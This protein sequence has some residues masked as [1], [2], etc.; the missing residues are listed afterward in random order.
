MKCELITEYVHICVSYVCGRLRESVMSQAVPAV[1]LRMRATPSVVINKTLRKN[2]APAVLRQSKLR[3]VAAIYVTLFLRSVGY[4][5]AQELQNFSETGLLSL[6]SISC[7]CVAAQAALKSW[8]IFAAAPYVRLLFESVSLM[9]SVC[10][11]VLSYLIGSVL[12]YIFIMVIVVAVIFGTVCPLFV[13]DFRFSDR[14]NVSPVKMWTYGGTLIAAFFCA[15]TVVGYFIT[16][17]TGTIGWL[18]STVGALLTFALQ[19]F[20]ICDGASCILL[21]AF[22]FLATKQFSDANRVDPNRGN[23]LFDNNRRT[24]AT[25]CSICLGSFDT[26]SAAHKRTLGCSHKFHRACIEQWFQVRC[27]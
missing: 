10:G 2:F 5:H 14:S 12:C 1:V 23:P 11:S 18:F 17:L 13:E 7:M 6:W 3:E 27:N 19:L 24:D 8:L 26:G 15:G 9:C 22:S 20:A 21:G 4:V 16:L 25:E